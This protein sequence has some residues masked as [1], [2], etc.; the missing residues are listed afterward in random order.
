[1]ARL[2]VMATGEMREV[3][4]VNVSAGGAL[5]ET[6]PLAEGTGVRLQIRR[7]DGQQLDILAVVTRAHAA[8]DGEPERVALRFEEVSRS[9]VAVA[10]KV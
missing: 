8:E 6:G 2:R 1:M 10:K 9:A 4:I 3:R 7:P 5:V